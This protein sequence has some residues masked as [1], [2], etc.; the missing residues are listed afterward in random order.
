MP[1]VSFRLWSSHETP[2]LKLNGFFACLSPGGGGGGGGAGSSGRGG[3]GSF[4]KGGGSLGGGG[5]TALKPRCTEIGLNPELVLVELLN[6]IL[7][8]VLILFTEGTKN[9]VSGQQRKSLLQFLADS[10]VNW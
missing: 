1:V 9:F 4:G 3:A 6:A 7:N 8:P 5:G 10:F 2:I